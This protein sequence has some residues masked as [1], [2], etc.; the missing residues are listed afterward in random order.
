M[1]QL[2]TKVVVYEILLLL[3]RIEHHSIIELRDMNF[4]RQ[5]L[6]LPFFGNLCM[7]EKLFTC[8]SCL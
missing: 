3:A 2:N 8:S 6:W 5:S 1:V 4:L 7:D